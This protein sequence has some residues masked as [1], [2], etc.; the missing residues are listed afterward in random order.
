VP[1]VFARLVDGLVPPGAHVHLGR[2]V[3]VTAPT[4][5]AGAAMRDDRL[6]DGGVD[7]GVEAPIG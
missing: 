7:G 1:V 3:V 5:E 2:I 4:G 6:V